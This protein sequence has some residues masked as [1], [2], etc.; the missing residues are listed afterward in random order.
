MSE[1]S[2]K[3]C[4]VCG[5]EL[6]TGKAKFPAPHS[7]LGLIEARGNYYSDKTSEKYESHPVKKLFKK[8]DKLFTIQIWGVNNPA[9]YCKE[10][11]KVFAEFEGTDEI[12]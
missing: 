6:D 3:Y 9:G 12:Y 8:Y 1:L 7:I 2:F 4:P 5:K 10:C 11:N